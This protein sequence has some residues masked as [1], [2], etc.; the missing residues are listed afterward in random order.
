M[1]KVE[2]LEAILIKE[3][4][5]RG[6]LE[7]QLKEVQLRLESTIT[8]TKPLQKDSA[9]H[10][11]YSG[12]CA[13]EN[14]CRSSN[15]KQATMNSIAVT[16]IKRNLK[17]NTKRVPPSSSS[18]TK[19]SLKQGHMSTLVQRTTTASIIRKAGV[20]KAIYMQ[21][22]VG[23]CPK[24]FSSA[25]HSP[26]FI[27][28]D[29]SQHSA[30]PY[31]STSQQ[32]RRSPPLGLSQC[33]T[34]E[35][36][37]HK[38]Q[39]A[40]IYYTPQITKSLSAHHQSQYPNDSSSQPAH[41]S[42]HFTSRYASTKT[43]H[44]PTASRCVGCVPQDRNKPLLTSR[45]FL[46]A[47]SIDTQTCRHHKKLAESMLYKQPMVLDGERMC[48]STS[49]DRTRSRV[50]FCQKET[51]LVNF[52]YKSLHTPPSNTV[53][54]DLTPIAKEQSPE[55]DS[56]LETICIDSVLEPLS[57]HTVTS[58]DRTL[59]LESVIDHS[60]AVAT[61]VKYRRKSGMCYSTSIINYC[62]D[63]VLFSPLH[64]CMHSYYKATQ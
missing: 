2:E 49:K 14:E 61:D 44:V 42:S 45:L 33:G 27:T 17:P 56:T 38:H 13:R 7:Q 24:D 22:P 6:K 40:H 8:S 25:C 35:R 62:S 63:I 29:M 15:E 53:D 11:N 23:S 30:Q 46:P 1:S 34:K 43:V 31:C 41:I 18:I 32:K 3:R 9:D 51:P 58:S 39:S 55:A 57:S 26:Q 21:K 4:E 10:D 20:H 47:I 12:S 36:T 16:A 60:P 5:K 50:A 37:T 19:A 54:L 59:V 52:M 28:S 48:G 64:M